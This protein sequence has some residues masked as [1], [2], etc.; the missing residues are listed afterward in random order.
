[1]NHL[2]LNKYKMKSPIIS[3]NKKFI[4]KITKRELGLMNFYFPI[5]LR[6]KKLNFIF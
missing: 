2:R 4:M 3:L 6:K 5:N 1:M